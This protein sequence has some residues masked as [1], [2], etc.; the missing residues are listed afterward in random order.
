[1][2]NTAAPFMYPSVETGNEEM[3]KKTHKSIG[4]W[5]ERQVQEERERKEKLRCD[6]VEQL[7]LKVKLGRRKLGLWCKSESTKKV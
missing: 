6:V 3:T 5:F 7:F 4:V 2:K 1:M